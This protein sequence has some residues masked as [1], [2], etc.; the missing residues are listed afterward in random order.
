MNVINEPYTFTPYKFISENKPE[1]L[2][3]IKTEINML[4]DVL[5]AQ[6]KQEA[7]IEHDEE[8]L[9][10]EYMYTCFKRNIEDNA[11]FSNW[12]ILKY[13]Y[14]MF[15][16][17][18]LK[19][20][21]GEWTYTSEDKEMLEYFNNIEV[22]N[23]NKTSS[24]KLKFNS[25]VEE[26]CSIIYSNLNPR[27]IYGEFES[28]DPSATNVAKLEY[29]QF[30]TDKLLYTENMLRRAKMLSPIPNVNDVDLFDAQYYEKKF[31]KLTYKP[32]FQKVIKFSTEKIKANWEKEQEQRELSKNITNNFFD[33]MAKFVDKNP[34][35]KKLQSELNMLY[36][37]LM[38]EY[39][40]TSEGMTLYNMLSKEQQA[41]ILDV[42]Y[43][44]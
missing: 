22:N 44:A 26:N 37:K 28:D 19:E 35:Y 36:F 11:Y 2:T 13:F 42:K 29:Y 8:L 33:G 12:T 5:Y 25:C 24:K 14:R 41:N 40:N 38:Q 23:S 15:R 20:M 32:E 31:I 27:Y 1:W 39:K 16:I 43:F 7:E 30:Y 4:I 6:L 10:E 18:V 3:N 34:M 17:K 9:T 21:I